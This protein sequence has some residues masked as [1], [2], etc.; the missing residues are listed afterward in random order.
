MKKNLL[1]RVVIIVIVTLLGLA[2]IFWPGRA[3]NAGDFTLAGL[4]NILRKNINLGLDLR[5]GSHLVMQVQVQDYLK[6]LTNDTTEGVRKAAA[7]QGYDVKE[8]RPEVNGNDY[9]IVLTANDNSKIAE[10]REQLPGKVNDFGATI[11]TPNVS[12]NT[13]TW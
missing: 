11:W 7:A 12:G 13:I 4:N 3:P 9:R 8:V 6:R 10:M 5:G 1:Q 2:A